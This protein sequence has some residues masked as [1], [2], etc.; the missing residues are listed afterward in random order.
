MKGKYLY[1]LLGVCAAAVLAMILALSLG[2]QQPQRPAFTPPPFDELAQPGVPEVPEDMGYGEVDAR[3]FKVSVCGRITVTDGSADVYLTNPENNYAW[4]KLRALDKNG[5][6]LGET[7]LIRPGEYVQKLTFTQIPSNG[8]SI[9]LKIMA[10]EPNTY[11]S[12]GS[13]N[14]NTVVGG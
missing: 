11:Y 9:T 6:I 5:N 4:L 13:A 14:L 7:G 2:G 8:D 12:A 10:Y 1:L 3:L